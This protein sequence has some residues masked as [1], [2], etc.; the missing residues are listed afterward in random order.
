MLQGTSTI[1]AHGDSESRR[2][3]DVLLLPS[4][5]A[6]WIKLGGGEGSHK[7]PLEGNAHS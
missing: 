7:G 2:Q 6:A 3:Q 4:E 1:A 5:V